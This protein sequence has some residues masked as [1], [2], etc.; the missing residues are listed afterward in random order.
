MSVDPAVVN[1][2]TIIDVIKN[3]T[4]FLR[5]REHE[6]DSWHKLWLYGFLITHSAMILLTVFLVKFTKHIPSKRHQRPSP[7]GRNESP[8][9]ASGGQAAH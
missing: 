7:L 6:R 2:T 9:A 3:E 5:I 4:L 8:T 1:E